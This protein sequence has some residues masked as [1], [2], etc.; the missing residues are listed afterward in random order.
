MKAAFKR[1]PAVSILSLPGSLPVAQVADDVD[2][3]AV[4]APFVERLECLDA[5]DLTHDAFWRDSF[6]LTGTL[7][8]F[9]SASVVA[10]AWKERASRHR[11]VCFTLN[12]HSP[13]IA[14]YGPKRA[15][16][17]AGFTFETEGPLATK[18]SGFISLIPDSNGG[19]KIWL[20]R[21]ILEQLKGYANPDVLTPRA[22]LA[23]GTANGGNGHAESAAQIANGSSNGVNGHAKPAAETTNGS[24]NGIN[25]YAI[26]PAEMTNGSTDG[27]NGYAKPTAGRT[28]GSSNSVNGQNGLNKPVAN[29]T[30]RGTPNGINGSAE[31]SHVDCVIV[32]AG[33]AGLSTAGRMKA[34]GVT[35]IVLD[36]HPRVGDNWMLRYDSVKRE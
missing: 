13:R 29:G 34:L 7:R 14:R 26:P 32:G 36:R 31:P 20:L 30:F 28:D 6:A 15:W 27:V 3:A 16:V 5:D 12:P 10:A 24:Y 21:T 8:T 25:A 23:N 17:E 22:E 33:Q 18:C 11:L 19:W 35:C 2:P 9:Y 4:A 1:T